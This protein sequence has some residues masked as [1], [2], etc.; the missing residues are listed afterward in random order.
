MYVFTDVDCPFCAR[1]EQT[2]Q[3]VDNVTVYNFMYPID[4]LH[5]AARNKQK[6][7]WCAKGSPR[8]LA[9]RRA[10]QKFDATGQGRLPIRSTQQL[11]WA[12]SWVFAPPVVLSGGWSHGRR[13]DSREQL[14]ARLNAAQTKVAARSREQSVVARRSS[15]F[16]ISSFRHLTAGEMQWASWTSSRKS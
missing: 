2:L 8:R 9:G 14:E 3:D 15:S 12:R 7:I 11:S 13:C 10:A 5:P 1:L 4:S 16:V 6:A